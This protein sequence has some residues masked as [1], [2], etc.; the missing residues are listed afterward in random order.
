M[1]CSGL[2]LYKQTAE[3]WARP[4]EMGLQTATLSSIPSIPASSCWQIRLPHVGCSKHTR[5][6]PPKRWWRALCRYLALALKGELHSCMS[7][8]S[9]DISVV[10]M[11]QQNMCCV[12]TLS[13]SCGIIYSQISQ[14][15]LS[16]AGLCH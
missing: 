12:C 7:S 16:I 13:S 2:L 15:L 1:K 11:T 4:K 3:A 14:Q 10:K 6:L 9:E 5:Q 8:K